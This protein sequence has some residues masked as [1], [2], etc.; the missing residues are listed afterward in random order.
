MSLD[1]CDTQLFRSKSQAF[2]QSSHFPKKKKKLTPH[3]APQLKPAEASSTKISVQRTGGITLKHKTAVTLFAILHAL[4]YKRLQCAHIL[5]TRKR[6]C[7]Y[8]HF[9]LV[10][11]F[12]AFCIISH[13]PLQTLSI[14]W[15]KN[16]SW[17]A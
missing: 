7:I 5:K 12:C 8:F 17:N 13:R 16:C 14:R 4:F 3:C 2:V 6:K 10:V 15:S 11:N 9:L 1:R